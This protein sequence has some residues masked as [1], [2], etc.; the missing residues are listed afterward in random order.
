MFN[1][2]WIEFV[3]AFVSGV[4]ATDSRWGWSLFFALIW[5]ILD[6]VGRNE[7]VIGGQE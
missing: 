6:A 2:K 7:A 5:L 4:M 3:A 1:S